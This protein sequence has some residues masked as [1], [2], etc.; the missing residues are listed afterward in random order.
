MMTA[1]EFNLVA[2]EFG[3]TLKVIA[4]NNNDLLRNAEF[5]IFWQTVRGFTYV[6]RISNPRFDTNRFNDFINEVALGQRDSYG[7]LIKPI[8]EKA[9]A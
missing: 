1:K 9:G 5:N 7:K 4:A 2:I 6:A 8:K 3:L